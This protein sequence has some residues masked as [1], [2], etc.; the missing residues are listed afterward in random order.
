M[1]VG[2]AEHQSA[3]HIGDGPGHCHRR[4]EAARAARQ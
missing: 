3:H 2:G 1:A 4:V